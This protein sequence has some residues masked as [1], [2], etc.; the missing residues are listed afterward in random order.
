MSAIFASSGSTMDPN[1]CTIYM[2][3]VEI[4]GTVTSTVLVERFGRK[5]LLLSSTAGMAASMFAFGIF[6][7]F[8]DEATRAQYDWTPLVLMAL[9]V[10][11]AAFGIV[12]LT[13]T[14][15]VEIL[16]AKVSKWLIAKM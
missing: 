4:A 5:V 13:Y 2:G 10:Y 11:T 7:Q 3:V 16:P 12:G 1:E 15:I 14:I 8:T 6:V 9:V